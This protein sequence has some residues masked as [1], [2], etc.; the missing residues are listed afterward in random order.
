MAFGLYFS[1]LWMLWLYF[2]LLFLYRFSLIVTPFE[3]YFSK[4][5]KKKALCEQDDRDYIIYREMKWNKISRGCRNITWTIH[6]WSWLDLT[7]LEMHVCT[8][9]PANLTNASSSWRCLLWPDKPTEKENIAG[10]F[11]FSWKPEKS[12]VRL[13]HVQFT[14][15]L[16]KG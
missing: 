15:A 16:V 12:V 10:V 6:M 13:R 3:K 9:R 5:K 4:I 7:Q 14:D 2:V 1:L 8:R 11:S